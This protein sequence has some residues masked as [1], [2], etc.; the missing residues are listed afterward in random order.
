[1]SAAATSFADRLLAYAPYRLA[2]GRPDRF[3]AIETCLRRLALGGF[4]P[5]LIVDAGARRGGFAVV[6]RRLFPQAAIH[7]IEPQPDCA[8]ELRRLT[9]RRGFFF[10]PVA[11][12]AARGVLYM[13]AGGEGSGARVVA[14]DAADLR[15]EATT[16]DQLFAGR[17]AAPGERVL[18]KL[19]LQG[20]ELCAL[21][22]ASTFL[23]RVEVVQVDVAFFRQGVEPSIRDVI[24][25]LDAAGFEL[26]DVAALTSRSRDGRLR[27]G[28]LVFVRRGTRLWRDRAWE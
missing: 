10:H 26:F 4:A 12:T 17:A 20:H 21:S 2:P 24:D 1:M 14:Q 5:G 16:L 11:V 25:F 19:D 6:A 18:L 13:R 22:G 7:M 3:G 27:Q 8:A 23:P 9:M 28:D 15:V